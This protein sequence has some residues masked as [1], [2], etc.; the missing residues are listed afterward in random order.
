MEN[1]DYNSE[2]EKEDFISIVMPNFNRQKYIGEQLSSLISQI[3]QNWELVVVDDCSTD[4]SRE[5][6]REFVKNN[7]D[8]KIQFVENEKTLGVAKN[9]EKGLQF[10][11]GEYIAVCDS[12]DVWFPDK[13]E[14]ELQFLKKGGYGMVYSDLVVVDEKLRKIKASFIKN[15]LSPFSNQKDDSFDELIHDNHI[16]APT[17]LLSSELK[18]KLVPFSQYGMQDYW[19]AL[20]FSMFSSIGYLDQQT[21]YYRQHT[22]NVVGAK[23]FSFFGLVLS[24][25]KD[26]LE[27]HTVLK[28][29][30]RLFFRDLSNVEGLEKKY[31]DKIGRKIDKL[32]ILV[33][34]LS[35]LKN[36]KGNFWHC[37]SKLWKLKARREMLQIIYFKIF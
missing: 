27:K 9:F 35:N 13:L 37:I 30:S 4:G 7:P 3:H 24:K 34:Y 12:D 6:I 33:E 10:A 14:K 21:I 2:T 29:N 25:N 16:T 22:E 23:K 5:I 31:A 1:K 20:I 36:G 8:R 17:I 15:F 19:I 18:K 26:F 32:E 28:K 11:T